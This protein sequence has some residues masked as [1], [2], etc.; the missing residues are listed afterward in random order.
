MLVNIALAT[1]TDKLPN[2]SSFTQKLIFQSHKVQL[3]VEEQRVL[4]TFPGVF[5]D[6]PRINIQWAESEERAED[7]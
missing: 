2:C 4:S 3:A 7:R 1:V 5:P 6:H